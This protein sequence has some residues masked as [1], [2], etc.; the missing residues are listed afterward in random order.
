MAKSAPAKKKTVA[1]VR[2]RAAKR[3]SSPSIDTDKSLKDAKP[4]SETKTPAVLGIHHG[5]GITKKSKNGRKAVLS[6]KA[7][8]R[9]EISMDR[10]EAAMDKKST[11]IEKSKDRARTIQSRSKTWDEQNRRMLARKELEAAIAIERAQGGDWVDESGDEEA[12]EAT[13][14]APTDT[15]DVQMDVEAAPLAAATAG[16]VAAEEDEEEEL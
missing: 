14:A 10:A 3:A 16:A 11:K 12:D 9:Q 4:P 13:E 7:K 8:R 2:S 5:A 15:G 6:A 1:S